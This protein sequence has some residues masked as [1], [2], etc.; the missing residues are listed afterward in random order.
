MTLQELVRKLQCDTLTFP[1]QNRH[2]VGGLFQP[3]PKLLQ[4]IN[5]Y[6]NETDEAKFAIAKM[7][8]RLIANL[9]YDN[10]MVCQLLYL[11]D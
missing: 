11:R 5:D 9:C 3:L 1:V 2:L 4:Y 10:R 7:S 8:V 6:M